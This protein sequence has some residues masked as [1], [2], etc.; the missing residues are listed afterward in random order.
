MRVTEK[1]INQEEA[2]VLSKILFITFK[3][4]VFTDDELKLVVAI[5][6]VILVYDES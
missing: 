5:A 1:K 2:S 3:F 4:W 6:E